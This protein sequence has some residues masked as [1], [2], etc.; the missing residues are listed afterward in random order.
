MRYLLAAEVEL[1]SVAAAHLL[2]VFCAEEGD[3]VAQLHA[4][5]VPLHL[6]EHDAI[7]SRR[8]LDRRIQVRQLNAVIY[9]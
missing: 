1:Q 2:D 6:R 9:Q 4:I 8:Q 3:F 7:A 5:V